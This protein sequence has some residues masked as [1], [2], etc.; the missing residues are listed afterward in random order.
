MHEEEPQVARERPERPLGR[1]AA[2]EVLEQRPFEP[3]LARELAQRS[4]RVVVIRVGRAGR[5][6]RHRACRHRRPGGKLGVGAT[7]GP[8]GPTRIATTRC[9]RARV[10]ERVPV[11]TDV[12]RAPRPRPSSPSGPGRSRATCGSSSCTRSKAYLFRREPDHPAGG[13]GP[14]FQ[15]AGREGELPPSS[16]GRDGTV[17][18]AIPVAADNLSGQCTELIARGRALAHPCARVR[19][20]PPVPGPGAM[21]TTP[22]GGRRP[23][24][25]MPLRAAPEVASRGCLASDTRVGPI[26]RRRTAPTRVRVPVR[27]PPRGPMCDRDAPRVPELA[28]RE[29]PRFS[30]GVY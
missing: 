14:P 4:H 7:R 30:R 27:A 3:V 12:A 29:A 28:G 2:G 8:R 13:A 9:E 6:R 15:S 26:V 16:V 5:R 18:R 21:T 10:P 20:A 1:M 19:N 24:R 25:A 22:P 17:R 11:R 23:N